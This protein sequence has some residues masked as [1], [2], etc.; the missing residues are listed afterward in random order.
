MRFDKTTQRK[1][2]QSFAL[3]KKWSLGLFRV[4]NG[5]SSRN[6]NPETTFR[7]LHKKQRETEET[8]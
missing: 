3:N 5:A 7:V 2:I 4:I 8:A 1:G 6:S